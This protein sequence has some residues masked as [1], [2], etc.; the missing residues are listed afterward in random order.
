M[1]VRALKIWHILNKL[2]DSIYTFPSFF[3]SIKLN[4]NKTVHDFVDL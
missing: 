4:A 3:T 1:L 2:Q